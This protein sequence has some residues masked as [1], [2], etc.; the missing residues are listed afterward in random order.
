MRPFTYVQ[1]T[2]VRDAVAGVA[3][4]PGAAFVSGG[5]DLINLMKD[6]AQ[7]HDHVVD[8]NALPLS[9]VDVEPELI[10]LGA[11]ARMRD[12]AE[13]PD[14]RSRIPVVAEALLASASPQVRNVASIGGNLLQRTRCGYFRD[15][16]MPCNKREPGTGCPA[17]TGENRWH[18]VLGGSE[19]CIAVM[20]SDLAVALL[21]L[22][23]TVLTAGP[24]GERR[25]PLGEFYLLPGDTPHR[26]N[27]L[28]HG[29]LIVGV[30]V[31]TT[32]FAA[33]SRYLKVRDRAT[34]EFAVVSVAAA[35][36]LRGGQ[37]QD[38]RLAFGGIATRPWRAVDA[39][40]A[41]RGNQLTDDVLVKAAEQAVR[42][43]TP[44]EHNAF[45]TELAQRA[46]IDVL[47]GLR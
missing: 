9:D 40:A 33:R 37:V 11:L 44:R 26:E 2:A 23:A 14:V 22:E 42:G 3:N 20:P 36:E 10:R 39:E 6:G 25:V 35:V 28:G 19:Q 46:V 27:V 31:P 5:T 21:A 24:D 38:V 1:A 45:K 18:A 30:E 32:P 41:L 12:V 34:F 47:R 13:N 17:L 43:A 4:R 7:V 15:T 8:I 16:G 29:E